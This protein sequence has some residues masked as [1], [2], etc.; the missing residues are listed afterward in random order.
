MSTIE[1]IGAFDAGRPGEEDLIP[2]GR[3]Y[4]AFSTLLSTPPSLSQEEGLSPFTGIP[5][6]RGAPL[7]VSARREHRDQRAVDAGVTSV[8]V[9]DG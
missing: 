2:I 3:A 1:Q 7:G 6:R 9:E 5:H 4:Y 8:V